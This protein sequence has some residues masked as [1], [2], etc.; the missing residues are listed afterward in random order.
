MGYSHFMYSTYPIPTA[1]SRS[2]PLLRATNGCG[3]CNHNRA[4]CQVAAL[5]ELRSSPFP[6]SSWLAKGQ[7]VS[8]TQIL[9]CTA[10]IK[11]ISHI[12][13]ILTEK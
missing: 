4:L 1:A 2:A 11:H 10:C 9:A 12:G 3:A 7:Y 5:S 6:G 13:G 8:T